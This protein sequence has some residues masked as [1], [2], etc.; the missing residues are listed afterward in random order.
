MRHVRL[1]YSSIFVR[2]SV[3]F[4]WLP[5][6]VCVECMRMNAH[7]S[8]SMVHVCISQYTTTYGLIY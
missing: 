2:S 3:T 4:L 8:P 1:M 5:H 6:V 7:A